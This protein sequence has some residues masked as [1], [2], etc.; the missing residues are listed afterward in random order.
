ME[1][2]TASRIKSTETAASKVFEKRRAAVQVLFLLLIC[3]SP[4]L[5]VQSIQWFGD[6][7][8]AQVELERETYAQATAIAVQISEISDFSMY[9]PAIFAPTNTPPPAAYPLP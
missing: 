7:N 9:L 5:V 1:Q 6:Y 8:R 2:K 4:F 3:A